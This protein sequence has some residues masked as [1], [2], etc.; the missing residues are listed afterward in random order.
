LFDLATSEEPRQVLELGTDVST[1]AYSPDGTLLAS[2]SENGK[3]RV[4]SCAERR[5]VRELQDHEGSIVML[6]FQADGK[7]LLSLDATGMAIW[8]DVLT[9]QA[10]RTFVAQLLSGGMGHRADVS[11][12]GRL[13]A[14][15]ARGALQ[16]LSAE[17]GELMATSPGGDDGTRQVGFSGDGLRLVTTSVYG[18]VALWDP[19]SFTFVTSFRAHLL[20][21]QAVAFSPDGGRMATGGGT[22][23]DAVK[24]W[25]L[26]TLRELITLPGRG[27]VPRSV[28][29]SNDGRWLAACNKEGML[30]LWHAPSWEEIEAEEKRLK[31]GITPPTP[32]L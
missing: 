30:C 11:P 1:I 12:D 13:L 20:G 21:A 3:I 4:W 29:F 15:E 22:N 27:V 28:V 8:W 26:S 16:W 6:R 32:L 31:M 2:G 18:T 9:W 17:T 10:D 24:L 19:S 5:L 23:R 25:D 14:F 7:R